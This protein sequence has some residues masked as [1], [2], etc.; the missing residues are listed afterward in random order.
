MAAAPQKARPARW[1]GALDASVGAALARCAK[2]AA[3]ESATLAVMA[4]TIHG[5]TRRSRVLRGARTSG[6]QGWAGE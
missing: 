2:P 3:H 1:A 6:G 4:G 5:K